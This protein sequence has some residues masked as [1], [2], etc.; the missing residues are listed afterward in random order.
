MVDLQVDILDLRKMIREKVDEI[1]SDKK[2][3]DEVYYKMA[4]IEEDERFKRIRPLI[5]CEQEDCLYFGKENHTCDFP[6]D[7]V[8]EEC[9]YRLEKKAKQTILWKAFD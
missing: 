6:D 2:I 5:F 4:E 8:D 3:A 1:F 7:M 9:T